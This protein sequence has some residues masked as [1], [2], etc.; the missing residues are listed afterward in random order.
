MTIE[1]I[2]SKIAGSFWTARGLG[3]YPGLSYYSGYVHGILQSSSSLEA[4]GT[5]LQAERIY[6]TW[7]KQISGGD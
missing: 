7:N 4:L 2:R 6:K 3:G 5:L 1:E